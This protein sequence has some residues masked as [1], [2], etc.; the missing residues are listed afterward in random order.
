[1][2]YAH[3]W[4][5]VFY[6]EALSSSDTGDYCCV[7]NCVPKHSDARRSNAHGDQL[8]RK[9]LIDCYRGS[10]RCYAATR[11]QREAEWWKKG[12]DPTVHTIQYAGVTLL[13]LC[14]SFETVASA[15]AFNTQTQWTESK[16]DGLKNT[17]LRPEEP[18]SLLQSRLGSTP[19]SK[20]CLFF[21][22]QLIFDNW[23]A[24]CSEGCQIG[25]GK[26]GPIW[27]P[28]S[29]GRARCHTCARREFRRYQLYT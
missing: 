9:A 21:F 10:V 17:A 5:L 11:Q 25:A 2:K 6:C 26:S 20:V 12:S 22:L 19:Y 3:I 29:E 15:H 13:L 1:M 24:R 28:C 4:Y 18:N 27:Q 7:V 16:P 8:V 23:V 14:G